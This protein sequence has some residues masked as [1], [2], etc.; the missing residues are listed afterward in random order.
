MQSALAIDSLLNAAR[1]LEAAA[2]QH[3]ASAATSSFLIDSAISEEMELRDLISGKI[4]VKRPASTS[5]ATSSEPYTISRKSSSTK[6]SRTAHNEL[7]KNRRANLKDCLETLKSL[8]PDS[9][10][11]AKNTTLA[12]LTRAHDHI[13]CLDS[14]MALA[15][16]ELATLEAERRALI[17]DLSKLGAD[18][19]SLTIPEPIP[20]EIP[21]SQEPSRAPTP[22]SFINSSVPSS[23]RAS[24]SLPEY[25]PITKS[26]PSPSPLI[27]DPVKEGLVS[28][29][30]IC[31]P[32]RSLYPHFDLAQHASVLQELGLPLRHLIL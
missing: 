20:S 13:E 8:V 12:L 29:F 23:S 16:R 10:D 17:D 28:A 25:S 30:P 4:R 18:V 27:I 22:F 31:Y 2:A 1:F 7:E 3:Q 21:A 24:P 26:S 11:A 32:S 9:P 14:Q 15:D 5:S 19:S 6:Q